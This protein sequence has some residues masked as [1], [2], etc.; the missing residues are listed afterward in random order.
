[1]N[2]DP[3]IWFGLAC[4]CLAWF[5]FGAEIKLVEY[6]VKKPYISMANEGTEA[7]PLRPNRLLWSNQIYVAIKLGIHFCPYLMI[8][9]TM[10]DML[11]NGL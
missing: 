3:L 6:L 4:L 2:F 7:T 1:M 8:L 9:V 5:N 10:L 11:P